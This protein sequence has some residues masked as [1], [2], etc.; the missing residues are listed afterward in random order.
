MSNTNED[1]KCIVASVVIISIPFL[2]LLVYSFVNHGYS[3]A[4][5][6]FLCWM[7]IGGLI[8]CGV[9]NTAEEILRHTNKKSEAS[10]WIKA[11]A[12]SFGVIL[13]GS[14]LLSLLIIVMGI[15]SD[16]VQFLKIKYGI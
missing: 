8:S 1:T 16:F 11:F 10:D 5:A 12:I 15:F 14:I 6:T 9:S 4:L 7:I 2:L 13:I 3:G